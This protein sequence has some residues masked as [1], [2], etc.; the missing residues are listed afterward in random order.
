MWC[1]AGV[2]WECV[3]VRWASALSSVGE[4]NTA[5]MLQCVTALSRILGPVC[6]GWAGLTLGTMSATLSLGLKSVK[7]GKAVRLTLLVW[8]LKVLWTSLIRVR[9]L[10]RWQ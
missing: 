10:V 7:G 5:A 6:V 4:L 8:T 1:S 2:S 9:N 3:L